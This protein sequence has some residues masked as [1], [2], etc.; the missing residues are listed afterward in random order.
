MPNK[1]Y[2]EEHKKKSVEWAYNLIEKE[3]FVVLDTETTDKFENGGEIIQLA[4]IDHNGSPLMNELLWPKSG[5]IS[6][7]AQ[8]VHKISIESLA[9]KPTFND[10]Y[11]RLKTLTC[12]KIIIAYN[13]WF[14]KQVIELACK[15]YGLEQL[16]NS[17]E[18]A[19]LQFAKFNG[20]WNDYRNDFKWK[21]LVEAVKGLNIEVKDAHDALGDVRMTLDVIKAMAHEYVPLV[22]FA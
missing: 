5:K 19:M 9:G 8:A 11:T 7:G 12:D 6:P 21:K 4:V 1:S 17:W 16:P 22:F 2:F 13:V 10:I 20:E 3:N 15:L 14:D 18:C